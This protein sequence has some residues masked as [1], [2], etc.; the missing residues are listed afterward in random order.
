MS[1]L[2]ADKLKCE[3]KRLEKEN[4]QLKMMNKLQADSYIAGLQK[5]SDHWSM[6]FSMIVDMFEAQMNNDI[7]VTK[8]VY[9]PV[10]LNEFK[11]WF[12]EWAEGVNAIDAEDE[13]AG[14]EMAKLIDD[15]GF[16][17]TPKKVNVSLKEILGVKNALSR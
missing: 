12:K 13:N 3:I 2:Q 17:F 10:T 6:K 5:V 14:D 9:R 1:T 7:E 11:T 8:G 15:H 16:V 4:E